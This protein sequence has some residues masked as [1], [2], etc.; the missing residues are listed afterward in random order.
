M[1]EI[2]HPSIKTNV[3]L[4]ALYQILTLLTPLITAPY[5]A[6]VL[7]PEG[8]GISSFTTSIETYFAM[9]AALGTASYGTREI[10]RVRNDE[11]KRSQLFW[12]I[13]GLLIVTTVIC[14][15]AWLIFVSLSTTYKIYYLIL[16]I[17]LASTLFDVS[18]FF[19]G[20]E[21]FQYI[22]LR[23]TIFRILG[24]IALFV[25]VRDAGD[26]DIYIA[27]SG[28]SALLGG[29]SM[30][31]YLPR[32]VHRVP[33][34]TLRILPHFRETL[35]YFIPTVATSVYTV[36]DKTLI[37]LIT[38]SAE[39][40]GY[41]D[42]ATKIIRMGE[43]VSFG[44]LNS[45][46]EARI[47]YLFAQEKFKEIHD[48]IAKSIDLILFMSFLLVFGII[49][50]ANVFVP[51]F[52]GPGY[53]EVIPLM[54]VMSPIILI[55]GISNC[56]GGQ[57]YT[58]V[59]L[60]ALSAKFLIIGSVVNLILNLLL[61]PKLNSMGAVIAS[62]SAELVITI[63]YVRFCG[64][65]LTVKMLVTK[66]W[67]K[68]FAGV[69]FFVCIIQLPEL[70]KIHWLCLVVQIIV[71]VLMYVSLLFMLKDQTVGYMI[72]LVR[73]RLSRFEK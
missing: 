30:W 60:R 66:G 5:I 29:V 46:L 67:R 68:L 2:K 6:R 35:I 55:I 27:I 1:S 72:D 11:N 4:S 70:I 9:F 25:F 53:D 38:Q 64:D 57:Y 44:A 13:E 56:L 40:N 21:Q 42:Q 51:W 50:T 54:Q 26:T 49:G 34:S 63:L 48:F 69:I 16:T 39:Q 24:I 31:G 33:I 8:V 43:T 14:L 47:S 73:S 7:G 22:V 36:L 3:L 12:E 62:L 71:A 37:G 58:P 18:W 19:S 10:A 15:I 23:N 32:F 41:Y 45:V 59:G 28:L 61:I 65:Y 20:L 52:F 17:T